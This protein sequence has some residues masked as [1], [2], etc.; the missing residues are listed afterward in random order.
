M[1]G[2][3]WGPVSPP[4]GALRGS[5]A[6]GHRLTPRTSSRE[7]AFLESPPARLPAPPQPKGPRAP[8]THTRPPRQVLPQCRCRTPPPSC[9][10][11][12]WFALVS[13]R[14]AWP[15]S[16]S[17]R[18]RP[19]P[20]APPKPEVPARQPLQEGGTEKKKSGDWQPRRPMRVARC[21]RALSPRSASGAAQGW[22]GGGSDPGV[23]GPRA[24]LA[25]LCGR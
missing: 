4:S 12:P 13:R 20:A 2:S 9:P 3:A 7:P 16:S 22:W 1:L 23:S 19:R 18:P 14:P 21:G 5:L 10:G 8:R 15:A 25:R 11:C 24:R 6:P 17:T